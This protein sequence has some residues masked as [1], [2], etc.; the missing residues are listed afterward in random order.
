MK[1]LVIREIYPRNAVWQS[2]YYIMP[3]LRSAVIKRTACISR[4]VNYTNY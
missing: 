3:C 4:P 2:L 1:Q